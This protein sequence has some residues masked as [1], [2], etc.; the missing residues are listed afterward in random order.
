VSDDPPALV[1]RHYFVHGRV[2]GVGF[3]WF[4]RRV[5]E[6]LGLVGWVRNVPDGRVEAEAA[7]TPEQLAA[8]EQRLRQGPPGARVTNVEVVP[9]AGTPAR[10][11]FDIVR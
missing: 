9:L 6:E 10:E 2:Q 4:V 1:A 7:G 11:R 5:A 3:R 8:F